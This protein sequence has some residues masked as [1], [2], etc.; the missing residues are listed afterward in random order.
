MIVNLKNKK[1]KQII[2]VLPENFEPSIVK[3]KGKSPL[4]MCNK[5]KK[6]KFVEIEGKRNKYRMPKKKYVAP[7]PISSL[8]FYK[9]NPEDWR[10]RHICQYVKYK[11]RAIY[12]HLP[13]ELQ[14]HE[15]GYSSYAKERSRSWAYSKHLIDKFGRAKLPK[16]RLQHYID[17][18]FNEFNIT[19]TMALLSCNSWID[20]YSLKNRRKKML[21][22]TDKCIYE[23][24]SKK[25]YE[26]VREL[27]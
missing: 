18:C 16:K 10:P 24:R 20:Q 15:R 22:I 23:E 5:R 6:S 9:T 25:W 21:Q 26:R 13:L 14:W 1:A 27:E 8:S 17:W 11:F 4:I 3:I 7:D 19:P 2:I 12:G